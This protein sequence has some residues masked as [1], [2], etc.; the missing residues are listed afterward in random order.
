[1]GSPWCAPLS[2]LKYFVVIPPFMMHD[3]WLFNRVFIDLMK[4]L[5]NPYLLRLKLKID[6]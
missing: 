4:V 2:N 5:P 3:S 1:M 6:D